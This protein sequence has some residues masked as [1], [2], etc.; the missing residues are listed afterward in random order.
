MKS[1]FDVFIC[2][3]SEDKLETGIV[4]EE[5]EKRSISTWIDEKCLTP[6]K[7]WQMEIEDQIITI[8]SAAVFVG[9][10]DI[11]P[12]QRSE[13]RALL[14]QFVD[15]GCLVIPVI[16]MNTKS[17]PK[18]PIFLDQM[19][20]IDLRNDYQS[21]ISKLCSAI[22]QNYIASPAVDISGKPVPNR[23]GTPVIKVASEV[24]DTEVTGPVETYGA[25]GPNPT[26]GTIHVTSRLRNAKVGSITTVGHRYTERKK[27][28]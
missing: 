26:E 28:S 18:L 14:S 22:K 23:P 24:F 15:R 20:W 1:E 3:N 16:L 21:G 10:N 12:W 7:P 11:G 13:I 9:D 19:T 8:G 2:Y 25:I 6:G 4:V 17:E 5:L 27:D